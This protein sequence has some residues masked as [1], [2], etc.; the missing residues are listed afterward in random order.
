MKR[1]EKDQNKTDEHNAQK[2][3]RNNKN[4]LR[5]FLL[6]VGPLVVA[7]GA[8]YFY[9]TGGRIVKTDNAYVQ[10]DKATVSAEVSG[11]IVAVFVKENQLVKKG[12][13]L[14][15]IDERSY[16][17]ALNEAKATRQKV[18]AEIRTTKA[19]YRQKLNEL[20]L[21]KSDIDFAEKE[22]RR[23][24]TLDSNRA[25]AKAQLDTARHDLDVN[26]L[27][28]EIIRNETEQILAGL[29][30]KPEISAED[31]A[32]Y[33]LAQAEV[34]RAAMDLERTTVKA[35]FDG[36]VSKIPQVGK[37]VSTGSSV[38]SLIAGNDFWIEANLKETDLTYVKAGQ[39]VKVEIDAFPGYPIDGEVES[40]SPATGAEY[41]IIPA[42]NA[43]GNWVK[44]VQRIPVRVHVSQKGNDPQLC[45]GM[46]AVVEIDTD[47]QR[48]LPD[49]LS[50]FF[51]NKPELIKT[52]QADVRQ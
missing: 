10:A 6:V 16:E 12:E 50:R 30:G 39:Q 2:T 41:S 9:W 26:N 46:S 15:Q 1:M 5:R 8:S 51:T 35:S 52:A 37:H 23:Q 42:Q 13:P 19:N 27:R 33:R 45:A 22:F 36:L 11:P 38:M 18:L 40:I 25:V 48:P 24:S 32:A 29:E 28:L 4:A 17:I 34:E 3:K 47:H 31:V 14:F 44:V 7:L 43:T 21:A 20:K 49:I